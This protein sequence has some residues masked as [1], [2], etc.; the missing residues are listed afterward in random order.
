MIV[1]LWGLI[2]APNVRAAIVFGDIAGNQVNSGYGV[3]PTGGLNNAIAEG[4]TMTQTISLASVDLYLSNF[5]PAAGSNLALSIYS[6]SGG[7]PGSNL[8]NLST[9]VTAGASA[10]PVLVTFSGTGS[11][12]LTSGTKYWLDFYA[13][14]P[15]SGTGN[16]V[17]WD[18]VVDPGF[19][20][21]NPSGSGA[22]DVGQLRSV[23][24][25]NT[26]SGSPSTSQLRT[27]F[28]LNSVPE[29]AGIA[30][31]GLGGIF[32]AA[33]RRSRTAGAT[34]RC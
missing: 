16:S 17:Q 18:G 11:F 31:L 19:A 10:T 29:P 32:L 21:V 26:F 2:I 8:Y 15:A 14:N 34:L 1:F 23:G 22:T 20:L 28:E 13:T 24:G 6:D 12:T 4:F 33:R 25:G 30:L 3:G 7:L 27:A 9:N 5:A